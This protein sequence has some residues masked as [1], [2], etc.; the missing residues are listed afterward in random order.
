MPVECLLKEEGREE[1]YRLS[2]DIIR[3]DVKRKTEKLGELRYLEKY[4]VGGAEKEGGSDTID[5][6]L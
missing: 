1:C 5:K 6:L 4:F 3:L 2:L